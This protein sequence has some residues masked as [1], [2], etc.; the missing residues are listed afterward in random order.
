MANSLKNSRL[1][2][3]LAPAGSP[4]ALEAAF[5]AGADAV[6]LGGSRF[7]ARLNAHNFDP[8][9]LREAITH[10]HRMGGRVYL[11]LNTLVWDRELSDALEAAYEAASAGVD[12]LIIADV[13]AAA[14]IH[15]ALPELPLHASTQLSG[16][17]ASVGE[18]LVPFGFS[19]FVIAREAHMTDL[20]SAVANNP[21]E[22]E[23]FIHGALCVSHSGQCLF[24]SVVGGRSGNR[25]ECAQPCRLPYGCADC[26]QGSKATPQKGDRRSPRPDMENYPLSLKDLS[27]ASHVPALIEA[28]VSSLKI[29][30]RMKSPGYVGGVTAIW[31]KLLDEGRAATPDELSA[32][33]DL[34]S[35]G[36]FTDGYQVG[37]ITRA[38]M[39]VRTDSDKERTASAEK[40]AMIAKYPPHLPLSMTFTAEADRPVS[41]TVEAPLFRQG[42]DE[43]VSVTVTVEGDVPAVSEGAPLT[44][45]SVEKQL[46]RT[47]GT[48]YRAERI[49]AQVAPGLSLPLSRL[50]ALRREGLD[51]LDS[52]RMAAMPNPAAG[53]TPVTPAAVT[54]EMVACNREKATPAEIPCPLTAR[55]YTADQITPKAGDYFDLLYL[56]LGQKHPATLPS[57]KRGSILPPVI[58]DREAEAVEAELADAIRGGIRHLL[59]GNLGHLPLVYRTAERCGVPMEE[60]FIHGDLRLNTANTPA[61]ARFLSIGFCDLILSPELTLPRMRD[62]GSALGAPAAGAVVYGRLPLM[63]LEKCA[64]REVYRHMKPDAVCREVCARNT[65]VMRDRMG[66]DFPI[67]REDS[68]RGTGHR[69]LV[70]NSLPTGMSDRREE[71][72]RAGIRQRHFIF[73]VET[74][75]DVDRVIAA[76]RDGRPLGQE[77]RRM[78]K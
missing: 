51:R 21:L 14:L 6:Y 22:V 64:I 54:A 2:E 45:E 70:C 47:G 16:H 73:T 11:T 35:R 27:L 26:R 52:A 75:A 61:A 69:N 46:A 23:V 1:P 5:R 53:Y 19:R 50:N 77:V 56:P 60:L 49:T 44:A 43:S 59:V 41:L 4:E 74:P 72:S 12:A 24:S 62:I 76:Y 32:L 67:L 37:K 18:V 55:F 66:K 39:G 25:G 65:A 9:Q 78:L 36:G 10:A 29:E 33:E 13:G 38:M 58:F 34:F 31:R 15:R 40:A 30:G 71:L 68:P 17:N 57:N 8:A 28:G 63:I 42:G 7:N 48:P 3:L 20:A